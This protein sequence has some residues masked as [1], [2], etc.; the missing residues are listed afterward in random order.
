M[1]CVSLLVK[2]NYYYETLGNKIG[3]NIERDVYTT[4]VSSVDLKYQLENFTPANLSGRSLNL[5]A[6][7]S[8]VDF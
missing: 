7:F 2:I 3:F 4:R 1:I 8:C 5:I 6:D